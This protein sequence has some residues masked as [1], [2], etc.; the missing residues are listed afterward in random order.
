MPI[1]K[2]IDEEP[3]NLPTLKDYLKKIKKRDEELNYRATKTEEYVSQF[4]LLKPK[5]AKEL[6]TALE[7]LKISRL[8]EIHIHK[9]I[10]VCPQSTNGLKALFA[11][12][13]LSLSTD[14][15]KKILAAVREDPN[16]M[17]Y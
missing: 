5:E 15:V 17:N 10:D 11:G 13:P 8:R 4:D 3:I 14:N 7:E 9:I 6:Y 2:V 16:G 12:T 1:P